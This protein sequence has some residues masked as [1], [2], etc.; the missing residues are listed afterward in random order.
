VT[1][2]VVMLLG[3]TL[4]P[5]AGLGLLLWLSHLEETLPRDVRSALRSPP[6]PPILAIEVRRPEPLARPDRPAVEA[7]PEPRL[8]RQRSAPA[9]E[10]RAAQ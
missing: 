8:A 2:V 7:A 10:A 4:F 6:P 9:V 3:V 5:A 1:A